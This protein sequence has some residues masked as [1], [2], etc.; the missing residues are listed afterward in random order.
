MPS[1]PQVSLSQCSALPVPAQHTHRAVGDQRTK[2]DQARQSFPPPRRSEASALRLEG[3][4]FWA[5]HTSALHLPER[6]PSQENSRRYRAVSSAAAHS[7]LLD[8]HSIAETSL[9]GDF[10]L[11]LPQGE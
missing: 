9:F 6:H 10:R 7:V 1:F 2:Y 8:F 3:V 5:H 11:V 4:V